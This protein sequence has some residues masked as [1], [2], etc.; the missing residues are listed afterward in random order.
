MFDEERVM[1]TN[2]TTTCRWK[3]PWVTV[4]TVRA[5]NNKLMAQRGQAPEPRVVHAAARES[6]AESGRRAMAVMQA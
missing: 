6:I 3:R 5:A 1:S 4:H 2:A